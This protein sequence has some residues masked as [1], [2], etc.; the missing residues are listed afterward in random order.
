MI[1]MSQEASNIHCSWFHLIVQ[2]KS[3]SMV[4]GSIQLT[5]YRKIEFPKRGPISQGSSDD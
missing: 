5:P 2:H 4:T 1:N 3:A